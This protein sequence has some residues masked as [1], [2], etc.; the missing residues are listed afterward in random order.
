MS[1]FRVS[2]S[3][4]ISG[5]VPMVPAAVV[6]VT[7]SWSENEVLIEPSLVV[8]KNLNVSALGRVTVSV[9]ACGV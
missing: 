7:V 9:S 5:E 8:A 3:M 4:A 1:P 2:N 6:S